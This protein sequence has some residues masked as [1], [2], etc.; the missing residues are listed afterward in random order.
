MKYNFERP[1]ECVCDRCVCG[2]RMTHSICW[3]C[4]LHAQYGDMYVM[5]DI[6]TFTLTYSHALTYPRSFLLE[7]EKEN[8]SLFPARGDFSNLCSSS[9]FSKESGLLF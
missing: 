1:L 6:C 9:I 3:V 8:L 4:G 7:K 5:W 2:Y